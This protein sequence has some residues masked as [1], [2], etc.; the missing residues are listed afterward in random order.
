M[1]IALFN[2]AQASAA[3]PSDNSDVKIKVSMELCWN[4][5]EGVKRKNLEEACPTATLSTT[6][7]TMD[8]PGLE[9]DRPDAWNWKLRQYTVLRAAVR[10]S[11]NTHC[12]YYTGGRVI[13]RE[14][15]VCVAVRV[16]V[17]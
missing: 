7:L 2:G 11:K 10:T 15:I 12:S 3:C 17:G 13:W 8:C 4:D 1:W 16:S 14:K 9:S 5:T 6:N